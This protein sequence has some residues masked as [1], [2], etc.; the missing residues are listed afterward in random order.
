MSSFVGV[1]GGRP[2]RTRTNGTALRGT[3]WWTAI[4]DGGLG[5]CS[6]SINTNTT[7]N[8]NATAPLRP[9]AGGI[10]NNND[11]ITTLDARTPGIVARTAR[12]IMRKNEPPIMIAISLKRT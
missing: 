10:I 9:V 4:K 3:L 12:E 5:R 8:A 1:L 11:N 7:V 6:N 2:G